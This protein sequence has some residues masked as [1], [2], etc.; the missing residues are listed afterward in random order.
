MPWSLTH[1]DRT[2][3]V[4]VNGPMD[5]G[6][7]DQLLDAVVEATQEKEID[8]VRLPERVPGGMPSDARLL[9]A[10]GTVLR[11]RGF[12]VVAGEAN[13][14]RPGSAAPGSSPSP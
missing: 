2:L 10:L 13:P 6:R 9:E 7:W 14:P 12:A 5:G 1:E 4:H 8:T 3:Q 11:A